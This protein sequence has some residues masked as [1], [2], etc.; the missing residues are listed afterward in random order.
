MKNIL[1]ALCC[2]I[3]HAAFGQYLLNGGF[4]ENDYELGFCKFD[5]SNVYY[6][7]YVN[8]STAFGI[9]PGEIDVIHNE[10][11]LPIAE[12]GYPIWGGGTRR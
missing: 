11:T 6:N 7:M 8:H 4:E 9:L 10:C 5:Q 12:L 1:F 2:L 3:A